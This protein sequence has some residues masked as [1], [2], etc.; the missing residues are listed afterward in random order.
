MICLKLPILSFME[1]LIPQNIKSITLYRILINFVYEMKQ[2]RI[3]T[4]KYIE[5]VIIKTSL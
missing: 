4:Y 3:K 2:I 5:N 1:M